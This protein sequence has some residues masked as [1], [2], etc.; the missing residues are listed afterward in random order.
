MT[1]AE[2]IRKKTVSSEAAK[3][4]CSAQRGK[5]TINTVFSN[6]FWGGKDREG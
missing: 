1:G 6:L 5:A 4:R 3:N 2:V